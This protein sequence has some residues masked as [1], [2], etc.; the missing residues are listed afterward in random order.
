MLITGTFQLIYSKISG[1][2]I[3]LLTNLKTKI[4]T[5]AISIF[6]KGDS[7]HYNSTSFKGKSTMLNLYAI[8]RRNRLDFFNFI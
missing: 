7:L 3:V 4:I 6:T 2:F 5:A 8:I 1:Q